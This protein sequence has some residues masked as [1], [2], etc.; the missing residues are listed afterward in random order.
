MDKIDFDFGSSQSTWSTIVSTNRTFLDVDSVRSKILVVASQLCIL[1]CYQRGAIQGSCSLGW[2]MP[3]LTTCA[4]RQEP[5]S[6]QV[7]RPMPQHRA[8][9]LRRLYTQPASQRKNIISPLAATMSGQSKPPL[10]DPEARTPPQLSP[11]EKP[12][13]RLI[14]GYDD[15]PPVMVWVRRSWL[16]LLTLA[17]CTIASPIIYFFASPILP[18]YFPLFPGVRFTEWGMTHGLPLRPE[19]V[20]T[21]VSAGV[22]FLVPATIMGAMGL[23]MVRS[24]WDSNAAVCHHA[25][26]AAASARR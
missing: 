18:H 22:G 6:R 25:Q 10:I 3:P 15:K 8:Y 24:F 14:P 16:D 7:A 1:F 2:N 21:F 11:P 9:P 4:T 19:Y 26:N 20:N 23:W 12:H 17:L 5:P 13:N